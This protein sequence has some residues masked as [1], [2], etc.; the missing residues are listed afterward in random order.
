M[1]NSVGTH[2]IY[3]DTDG[4]TTE[5]TAV[6]PF[7][8]RSVCGVNGSSATATLTLVAYGTNPSMTT[9]GATTYTT[10]LVATLKVGPT[11]IVDL[12]VREDWA[13]TLYVT[14]TGTQANAAQLYVYLR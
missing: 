1:A 4:S 9:A 6:G 13:H 8:I 10:G 11:S 3:F 7:F 14:G 12:D 2:L 5:N